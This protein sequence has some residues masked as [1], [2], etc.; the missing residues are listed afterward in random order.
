ME[1]EQQLGAGRYRV[2]QIIGFVVG[3]AFVALGVLAFIAGGGPIV[4]AISFIGG[5]VV[6]AVSIIDMVRS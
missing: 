4:A 6:L 2:Y 5:I 1:D 3:A